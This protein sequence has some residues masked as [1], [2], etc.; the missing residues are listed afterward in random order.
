MVERIERCDDDGQADCP[1]C[2]GEVACDR[3][4]RVK[5][6]AAQPGQIMTAEEFTM[7]LDGLDAAPTGSH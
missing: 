6:A 4:E 2:T 3:V 7:W 5:T 1:I